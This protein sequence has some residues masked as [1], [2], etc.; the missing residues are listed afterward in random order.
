[1]NMKKF[2]V[3]KVNKKAPNKVVVELEEGQDED[4]TFEFQDSVLAC[5][6]ELQ[7][8]AISIKERANQMEFE[9]KRLRTSI[10]GE[11]IDE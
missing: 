2:T 8:L 4:S 10:H 7:H 3:L 6:C 9:I 1:M 5:L 11:D